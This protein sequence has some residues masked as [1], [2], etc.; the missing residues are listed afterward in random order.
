MRRFIKC[1]TFYIKCRT[2][3]KMYTRCGAKKSGFNRKAIVRLK[4]ELA[5]NRLKKLG[6]ILSLLIILSSC[7]KNGDITPEQPMH[8][9]SY[10]I[11][12]DSVCLN[13][14]ARGY[15]F[16]KEHRK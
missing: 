5:F 6:A 4:N 15:T 2:F 12:P 13:L 10:K 9:C 7:C 16:C 14:V 8:Q 3:Y 1:R 11:T